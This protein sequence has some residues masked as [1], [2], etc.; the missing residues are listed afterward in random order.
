LF[1]PGE[2]KRNH[3]TCIKCR[4]E[5]EENEKKD[6]REPPR[7]PRGASWRRFCVNPEK[8]SKLIEAG[9]FIGYDGF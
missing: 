6:R 2:F 5:R 1:T 4:K 7:P 8:V 3:P 9:V